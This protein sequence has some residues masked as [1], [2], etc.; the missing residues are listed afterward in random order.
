MCCQLE[1]LSIRLLKGGNV[2]KTLI[3]IK[4]RE[5]CILRRG[6]LFTPRVTTHVGKHSQVGREPI[7]E[8]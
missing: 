2:I 6:S 1:V 7:S 5:M 3:T 8:F 4:C